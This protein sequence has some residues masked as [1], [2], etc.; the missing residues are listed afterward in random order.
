MN[1]H[2]DPLTPV[3]GADA[4]LAE[5]LDALTEKLQAGEPVDL[6]AYARAHPECADELRQMLP[7][8]EML[9][10]LAR[11]TSGGPACRLAEGPGR[12]DELGVLGEFRLVREVGRG[13]MGVVYEAEQLSLGRRVALKVLPFAAALDARQLQRFKQE[14]QAA[15]QLHHTNIV[16]VYAVGSERGVHFYAMQFIDG[17]TLADVIAD[18][19][20]QR[21]RE[22]A[23]EMT[24]RHGVPAAET[25][26]P[27]AAVLSTR[28][29]ASSSAYFRTVARLGVQAAEALEHAHQLGVIHRDVKPANLLVDARGGL[30]V[31]D[32]GLAQVR[33]DAKLTLTGDV[34]GT[35]RY[36]SPEQALAQRDDLDHRTDIYSLGATLYELLTLEPACDGPDRHAVLRQIALEEPT[37]P[38][39][40]NRSVPPEL[41]TVVLKALAKS[42]EDRYATARELADDLQRYLKDEPIR[43][44]R[45]TPWQRARKWAR[46]H[47]PV[48]WSA[49]ACLLMALAA[50]SGSL[51][52][53]VRDRAARR[54]EMDQEAARAWQEA[55]QLYGLARGPEALAEA[56][57][58]RTLVEQGGRDERLRRQ[59]LDLVGDLEAVRKLEEVRLQT[60]EQWND[61]HVEQAEADYARAFRELGIDVDRLDPAEAAA[62]VRARMIRAELLAFLDQWV[63]VRRDRR[64]VA[65]DWRPLLAVS[66]AADPDPV[67]NR[68]RDAWEGGD[69]G[70]LLRLAAD[71]SVPELPPPTLLLLADSLVRHGAA[72]EAAALLRQAQRRAPG[73][74][75]INYNLGSL[76]KTSEP[77]EA[78]RFLTAAAA[79][80]P[81]SPGVHNTLG[82][83]LRA[84][85][86]LPAAL[87]AYRKAVELG[88]AMAWAHNNLGNALRDAGDLPASVAALRKALELD[89]RS[90]VTHTNLGSALYDAGD[91]AGAVAAFRKALEL[92]PNYAKAHNNLG[93]ALRDA[94][95]L[96]AAVAAYQKAVELDPQ[97]ALAYTNLGNGLRAQGDVPAAL[98]AFQK[99]IELDPKN[100]AAHT[101]LGTVLQDRGDLPGALAAHR[102]AIELDPKYAAAYTGLGAALRANRDL[103]G[104]V[105]AHRRATE[106]DPQFARGYFNLGVALRAAGDLPGA[107]AAYR[108]ATE[109]GPKYALAHNNL[110]GAL[111]D[112]GDLPGA[113][114]AYRTAAELKPD[115][116]EA[117]CGLGQALRRQ[118]HFAEALAA[119]RRGHELGRRRRDWPHPSERW[120]RQCERLVEW[121]ARLADFLRDETAPAGVAERLELARFA[122]RYR[123]RHGLAAR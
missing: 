57:R 65:K 13:G 55:V 95:D 111:K 16:P 35:L 33:G 5:L 106:L 68:V 101:G 61:L 62:R 36:M 120:V 21:D 94:G 110:G 115:F 12:D 88:P 11:S 49:A 105:A 20:R 80:R 44:K 87:A 52:W 75:W 54:A 32:F 108:R 19:R 56:R 73:D 40:R 17:R 118:G 6:E 10:Q 71:A 23:G 99:A 9:G 39:R 3:G 45:P 102:K 96:P 14:A 31:A 69:R 41:E 98:A 74:F 90:A 114:A 58:A 91:R 104:A 50:L 37:P 43:A 15:A 42:P 25:D 117:H 112:A 84:K 67:R 103:P 66:R 47:R 8:L 82:I 92:A 29:S 38:R 72:A 1:T 30:W 89:P 26:G 24:P 109:L 79:L 51:G 81:D 46:R 97:Y 107:V 34:V 4:V 70:A 60:T 48:V 27:L 22:P 59:V 93:T 113:V 116:A 77:A 2:P 83:A 53:A 122:G 18:L 121:D 119:L 64:F 123:Q 28:H 78:V 85:G 86:D 100:A 76:L 63:R 7:A